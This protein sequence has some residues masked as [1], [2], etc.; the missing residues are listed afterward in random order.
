MRTLLFLLSITLLGGVAET[1]AQCQISGNIIDTANEPLAYAHIVLESQRDKSQIVA[2]T[3]DKGFFCINEI[4]T[5]DYL[6]LVSR[7]GSEPYSTRVNITAD[8]VTINLND[9]RINVSNTKLSEIVVIG[10]AHVSEIKPSAIKYK[11]SSLISEAGG[12]A[13]D[14]LKNMPSVAMGG[15]PGHNRDIRFRGLGNAYTKV[16][17]NGREIG[18]SGNNRETILDQIP[19]ASIS[20]IEIVAVPGA[21]QNAEGINGIVNIVLKDSGN[22]GLHGK[23]EAFTGNNRSLGGGI[24]LSNKTGKANLYAHYDFLQRSVP[25]VKDKVKTDLKSGVVTQVETAREDESKSFTNH[26]LRTGFDYYLLPKT[27]WTGEYIMGYQLEDKERTLES[28]KTDANGKFKSASRELKTEYK[29]NQY[30]QFYTALE[31]SFGNNSKLYGNITR[32]LEEQEKEERKTTYALTKNGDWANY[33]PALENKFEK[34]GGNKTIWNGGI[35]KLDL[36]G[37]LLSLGYSGSHESRKFGSTTDKFNYADTTWSSTSNGLDNFKITETNHAIFVADEYNVGSF[38]LKAGLRYEWTNTKGI[39]GVGS[40]NASKSYH[41]LLPS[42]SVANNIDKTQYVTFNYGRRIRRPGFK[43]LN[44]Y[45]E[46]KE[47]AKFSK[48]NPALKPEI[49]WAYEMGY[50]KN[51]KKFNVGANLFYRDIKDVIQKTISEDD[52]GIVTEQPDN[53]GSAYVMGYELMTTVKPFEIWQLTASFSQFD[54]QITSGTYQGDALSDQ[55]KWAAKIITDLTLPYK[56]NIQ[57]AGNVV[58][59]K[60]SASKRENTIWF[61]DLGVEKKIYDNGSLTFRMTDVFGSLKKDKTEITDKS[62]TVESEYTD[63][64]IVMLGLSWRF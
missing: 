34:Q 59:P 46:Q 44:P 19:A 57:L 32:Q 55:Y 28:V 18:L 26:N 6:L 22:Y 20:H 25:K 50:L 60:M 27:K 14:I 47:P 17:I 63:G 8:D 45:T 12:T 56:W 41:L 36:A 35:T 62:T 21:E 61:A 30:H 4:S 10:D 43:D 64:Q 29:P 37:S 33:Q 15:S 16:L 13:G 1:M 48:G 40:M 9:I 23:A 39:T 31:H 11:T 5:G 54:S 51:F 58:G 7:V 24:S 2:M 3:D 53:T 38:R 49:A 42:A 52:N